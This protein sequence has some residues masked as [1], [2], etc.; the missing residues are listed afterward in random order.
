[1]N[2]KED[3]EPRQAKKSALIDRYERK[4]AGPPEEMAGP[5]QKTP[6]AG[7]RHGL[8]RLKTRFTRNQILLPPPI[9]L[10]SN[11]I[12]ATTSKIWIKPPVT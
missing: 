6:W 8:A 1:M 10:I 12:T 2:K 3:E 4:K 9:S 7:V 5:D 11:T